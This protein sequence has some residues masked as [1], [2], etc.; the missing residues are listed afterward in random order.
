M[1]QQASGEP[2]GPAAAARR[3]DRDD[4]GADR[5]PARERVRRASTRRCRSRAAHARA[6]RPRRPG[7]R[8]RRPSRSAR[9]TTRP[10]RAGSARERGWDVAADAGRGWRRS[11]PSP[12]PLRVLGAEHVERAARPRLVV[13]AGGGGGIPVAARD[14]EVAAWPASIDKDRCAARAGAGGRRRRARLLTGVPR[15]ALDFGTRWER[16]LARLTVAD[17][18]RA[19]SRTASSRP[20]AWARRSSR[21]RASSRPAGGRAVI[22]A[23]RASPRRSTART[24]RGSSPT[25]G[26][27]ALR[28]RRWRRELGGPHAPQPL[29][30]QRAADGGR[31]ARCATRRRA[32]CE[33]VMGTPANLRG[34]GRAR[35]ERRRRARP[36]W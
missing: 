32:A 10:R 23:P 12:R 20:A 15:V 13:I 30:R 7:V 27:V 18:L 33:V 17:A 29:R 11:S 2:R 36:T 3:A 28:R 5:L 34:A 6:R 19:A 1:L 16:E 4:P 22:T 24:A 35:R 25:R 9:S 8:R 14:G 26:P 21:P 31:A